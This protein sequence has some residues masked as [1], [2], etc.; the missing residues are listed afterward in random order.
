[1][2]M[3]Y[4]IELSKQILE[5]YNSGIIGRDEVPIPTEIPSIDHK[6]ILDLINQEQL[7]FTDL[8][9]EQFFIN[10]NITD[11]LKEEVLTSKN[12][13]NFKLLEKI[14]VSL[15]PYFAFGVLNGG[16]ATSYADFKKNESFNPELF[17]FIK[18]TFDSLSEN[19]RNL[20]KGITP[21]FINPNGKPGPSFLE[22]KFRKLLLETERFKQ[23]YK[24]NIKIP[25]FQMT[26]YNNNEVINDYYKKL[27]KS[28]FI[29]DL[30]DKK[31][32]DFDNIFTGI[33]PLITAYTH[34]KFGNI[35]NIFKDK[36]GN[37][38]PL[39]GGHGQIFITLREI[40]NKLRNNGIKFISIGNVDNIGYNINPVSIAILALS[41]KQ[42]AFDFSFKTQFDKKGGIL[43]K[44]QKGHLNCCDLGVA[45]DIDS[46]KDFDATSILFN[47]ASGIFNLEYL[48]DNLDYIIEKLPTRFSDQNKDIGLYSQ[49]EQVTWEIIG[50]LSDFL[51][52]A[53]DKY[54]NFLASKLLVENFITSGLTIDFDNEEIKKYTMLLHNGL[55]NKLKNCF[56]LDLKNGEWKPND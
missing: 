55:I 1:M 19:Y 27:D 43:I 54:D 42:A 8:Q 46:L 4:D 10:Y 6:T 14:G 24:T 33:Q 30:L 47:C 52:L 3:D 28:I 15:Y 21:A 31:Q 40:F 23:L 2:M 18:D 22:L 35:K 45:I 56:N 9:I 50:I 39:P 5:K 13:F 37:Y 53:V 25:F 36:N 41:G 7:E 29:K 12:C 16:S 34:S 38:Y 51:I 20:P 48:T 17:N 32:F 11:S 49:A 26:S 44:D